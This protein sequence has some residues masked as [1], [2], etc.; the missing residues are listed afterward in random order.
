[1]DTAQDTKIVKNVATTLY[2]RITNPFFGTF[3]L[4]WFV[5]NIDFILIVTGHSA[6]LDVLRN[7]YGYNA[8][9]NGKF[10][11]FLCS[12]SWSNAKLTHYFYIIIYN[13][14]FP[15]AMTFYTI[16]VL[17]P[18]IAKPIYKKYEK[19]RSDLRNIKKQAENAELLTEKES[20]E[21]KNQNEKLQYEV[22]RLN[23]DLQTQTKEAKY[24]NR[25]NTSKITSLK[26][27]KDKLH[28]EII[29]LRDN[30]SKA[31]YTS[32]NP[33]NYIE[34]IKESPKFDDFMKLYNADQN[35]E[36]DNHQEFVELASKKI[37][38]HEFISFL[39]LYRLGELTKHDNTL[40][41]NAGN[42]KRLFN[43]LKSKGIWKDA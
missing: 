15:C 25:D 20:C 19:E 23:T 42:C 17:Y 4:W 43:N 22:N 2:E 37:D 29:V 14:L 26:Q 7:Y 18:R 21:I 1:M 16:Y 32:Y 9:L 38:D 5:M 35:K 34:Q 33:L 31:E 24:T 30:L 13:A 36:K 41:L 8:C 3:F 27:E 6:T 11:S 28:A 40:E 12:Y 39:V 10:S